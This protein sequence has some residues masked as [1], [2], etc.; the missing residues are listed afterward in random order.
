MKIT[1]E[2]QA[3]LAMR[4]VRALLNKVQ[5]EQTRE[6]RMLLEKLADLVEFVIEPRPYYDPGAGR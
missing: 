1:T 2:H 4:D 5:F 6:E 3:R